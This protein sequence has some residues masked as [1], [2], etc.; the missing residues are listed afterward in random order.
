MEIQVMSV[1]KFV[2]KY[3]NL[4]GKDISKLTHV[5]LQHIFRLLEPKDWGQIPSYSKCVTKDGSIMINDSI[6]KKYINELMSGEAILI[7]DG[8]RIIAYKTP[9]VLYDTQE[10]Y[11]YSEQKTVVDDGYYDYSTMEESEIR[12]HLVRTEN[13][14]RNQ[15][16]AR[17]ELKRRKIPVTKK[18]DRNEFKRGWR[19]EE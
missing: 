10:P 7:D 2:S 4:S 18:Y 14:Y 5:D 16:E 3:F 19:D 11:T 15:V 8:H 1:S 17:K 9:Y 13:S 6:F 12:K